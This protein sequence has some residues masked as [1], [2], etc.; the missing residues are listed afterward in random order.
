MGFQE[1]VTEGKDRKLQEGFDSGYKSGFSQIQRS[2]ELKGFL[3]SILMK[4]PTEDD[5]RKGLENIINKISE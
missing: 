5:S 4:L 2:S 1:G 3:S